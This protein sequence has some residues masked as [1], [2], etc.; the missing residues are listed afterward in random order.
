MRRNN[1]KSYAHSFLFAVRLLTEE[2]SVNH[3][4]QVRS[5]LPVRLLEGDNV[6]HHMT[7]V[8]LKKCFLYT[9]AYKG[10]KASN[11]VGQARHWASPAPA[12]CVD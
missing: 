5:V 1:R 10:Q 6:F 8:A 7:G 11:A 4:T 2:G 3:I 9:K 12:G